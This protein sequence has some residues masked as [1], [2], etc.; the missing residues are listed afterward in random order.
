MSISITVLD[1]YTLNP[2]DLTWDLLNKIGTCKIH[3]RTPIDK[4][5]ERTI[6]SEIILTNKTPLD[7]ATIQK[8]P[9]LKYIGVLATGYNVIDIQAAK[10]RNIPVCNVPG[11]SGMS[12]AQAVFSLLL[13]ITN[14]AGQHSDEVRQGK[15]A[16]APDFCFT[17]TPLI[18]LADLTMG[19]VGYGNIA[20]STIKIAH[21]L[22][23]KTMV[24][25]RTVPK[26]QVLG[27]TFVSIEDIFKKSDVITLHCPLT[28]QTKNMVNS[29]SLSTMKKSAILINTG[30]G[31]LI[32]ES[33][34]AQALN[35][36]QI[37]GAGLDVLSQEPPATNNPLLT[38]KNCVIT[39][40]NAWASKAARQR[41]MNMAIENL[42][43]FLNNKTTNR[44]NV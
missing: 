18:E 41:L 30:R 35:A 17:S 39:P 27:V 1:G 40:H 36:N 11:Y 20:Q 26:D 12:V 42:Q 15:W 5:I 10:E 28:D 43:A 9:K 21:A 6:D 22:G 13:E 37:F 32:D 23:M 34:L 38:A 16:S 29:K 24:H 2:G 44:V 33:A 31:P 25:T 19:V 8:L 7:K 14:H 4:I 3:D